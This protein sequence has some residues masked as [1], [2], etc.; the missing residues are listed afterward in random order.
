MIPVSLRADGLYWPDC[1]SDACYTWTQTEIAHVDEIYAACDH[2]ACVIHAGANVGAYAQKFSHMFERV[3]AFEPDRANFKCLSLNTI[4]ILNIYPQF[5]ALGGH[6]GTVHMHNAESDNCGTWAVKPGLTEGSTPM[7]TIDSLNLTHVSCVHLD[8]EG[9]EWFALKGAQNT[10]T[11]CKPLVVVEWLNHGAAYDRT[12]Q[13]VQDLL[14][15][16]GYTR[17]KA[18]GSDMM[19]AQ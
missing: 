3:Y 12:N 5:A 11:S 14:C 6:T 4:D 1:D 19:F 8:L 2:H 18:I 16:W 7:I 9:Y 17:M 13:D 10:I 15:M